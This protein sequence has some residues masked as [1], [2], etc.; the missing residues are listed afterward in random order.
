MDDFSQEASEAEEIAYESK[1]TRH[2]RRTRLIHQEHATPGTAYTSPW[3]EFVTPWMDTKRSTD[4]KF[5]NT[6]AQ[7]TLPLVDA[8]I[9]YHSNS[10]GSFAWL[11]E[12]ILDLCLSTPAR[13]SQSLTSHPNTRDTALIS[14][15]GEQ[16]QLSKQKAEDT[17][18]VSTATRA[19]ATV[20]FPDVSLDAVQQPLVPQMDGSTEVPDSSA[21]NQSEP[22]TARLSTSDPFFD[23]VPKG[24]RQLSISRWDARFPTFNPLDTTRDQAPASPWIKTESSFDTGKHP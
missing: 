9:H 17:S 16:S 7:R 6:F 22:K 13:A 10:F 2:R 12:C 8:N 23:S 24:P 5:A 14:V 21:A 20:R 18:F 15:D 1:Q 19:S 4:T 3:I 11:T